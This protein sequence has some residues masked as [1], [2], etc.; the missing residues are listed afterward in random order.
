MSA[1]RYL[2]GLSVLTIYWS[3]LLLLM[4]L[5]FIVK[6]R[7]NID[8]YASVLYYGYLGDLSII[9]SLVAASSFIL[10]FRSL[11]NYK[12]SSKA[13]KTFSLL[14]LITIILVEYSSSLLYK[15]W[16]T[17]L[18][19]RAISYLNDSKIGWQTALSS[20]DHL[21]IT[22]II[23]AIIFTTFS[24]RF[25]DKYFG[26]SKIYSLKN[27]CI[28]SI[29]MLIISA[30]TVRGG[31]QKIP[32]TSAVSFFSYNTTENYAAVNK[33]RYFIDSYIQSQSIKRH[34]A[35]PDNNIELSN[36]RKSDSGPT[37]SK[38][39]RPNITLIIM[40][41]IPNVIFDSI[42]H[43]QINIPNLR[44]IKKSSYSF[45]NMY[46]SGFR[47]DQGLLSLL[48][49]IPAYPYINAIKD[50]EQIHR[51]ANLIETLNLEGYFTS[52]LYGG[53]GQFSELKKYMMSQ[54]VNYYS[55]Q[56]NFDPR[57]RTM[58]WG[59]PDH[60]L[61]EYSAQ[62][63][64]SLDQPHFTTILAS[65][66][67]L[68][69]DYPGNYPNE[70][71]P[72]ENFMGSLEYLDKAIGKLVDSI[73]VA[74]DNQLII[75]TSDHGCLYLGHDFN[76][77]KRFNVPFLI[78]GDAVSEQFLETT[79]LKIFNTHDLPKTIESILNIRA[80]NYPLSADMT[81]RDSTTSAYW[82]TENTLGWITP[83]QSIVTDHQ[84][85]QLYFQRDSLVETSRL[86][87]HA[88]DYYQST[89]KLLSESL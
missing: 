60:I 5:L 59:V 80:Q 35:L 82:I 13:L 72:K 55:D 85:N 31:L 50:V 89:I 63:I 43:D 9:L 73:S 11:K 22:Y 34:I 42:Y 70:K 76:D 51:Q 87:H 6:Y 86:L 78:L 68:P 37:F 66:T 23:T 67:H 30:I 41:G 32:K 7:T 56:S 28:L 58:D 48:A 38:S 69:F 45:E 49:G 12:R 52:F 33:V 2:Q 15:E 8:D 75:I 81:S 4:R 40:E 44:R 79:N 3:A 84:C 26:G 47:T 29:L 1:T 16:G 71:T 46:A 65:S 61:L 57:D 62:Y 77:H 21:A 24:F 83:N 74:D 19:W 25:I 17:T 27:R 54:H 64:N 36:I 14:S 18:T 88:C 39:T 10:L 53:D 20:I